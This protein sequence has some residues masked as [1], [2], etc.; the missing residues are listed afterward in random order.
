[1]R[2]IL[3]VLAAGL[4]AG[5]AL[6]HEFKA[7]SI[8]VEHP[9]AR[10]AAS[11]NGAAYF[12]LLNG[13]SASDRLV[14]VSSPAAGSAEMHA[15]S[16]DAQGVASMRPV[17]AVDLPAGGEAQFTPAGLHVMLVGLSQPLKEGQSFPLT[18]TLEKAGAV[19]VEVEVQAKPS[20]GAA[21]ATGHGHEQPSQ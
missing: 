13:G 17:Q 20:H 3:A 5:P 10:P 6:A 21:A 16:V 9:W 12:K 1:M 2:T 18:L 14:G 4:L 8:T 15:T 7:G 11:G 19:T